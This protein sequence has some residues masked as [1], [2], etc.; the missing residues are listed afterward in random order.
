MPMICYAHRDFRPASLEIVEQANEIIADYAEDD[1]TLTLRQLYYQFVARGLLANTQR[2]YKRLGGIVNDGRMAGLIDW[3]AIEDRTRNMQERP[4]WQTPAEIIESAARSYNLNTWIGQKYQPE[5]WIEKEALAGVIQRPC[6]DLDVPF[7]ACRGYTSQSEM[8]GAAMRL[9]R[10]RKNGRLPVII[11]LGDHD[12]SGIDMT[13]DIRERL[14][15]FFSYHGEAAP[16]VERIALN[17]D[18]VRE[19][20]PPPNP[21]KTTDSRFDGYMRRFGDESW[22]LDALDPRMLDR[23]VRRTIEQFMDADLRQERVDEQETH[24]EQLQKTSRNWTAVT[25]FVDEQ[26]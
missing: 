21:A 20:N 8:W 18:Q 25:D 4:H 9:L 11:H 15:V 26:E 22:E 19:H 16:L 5:V 2:N 10:Y 6:W 17:M 12:P 24:R 3:D 23:L 14:E 13:R 1:L 7:F